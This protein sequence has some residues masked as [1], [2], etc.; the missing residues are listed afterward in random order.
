MDIAALFEK[1]PPGGRLRNLCSPN[2]TLFG[3]LT[4]ETGGHP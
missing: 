2:Y 4:V 3:V 1:N